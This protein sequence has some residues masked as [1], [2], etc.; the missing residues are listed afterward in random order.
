MAELLDVTS[1]VEHGIVG[2]KMK[3]NKLGH[4]GDLILLR[5]LFKRKEGSGRDIHSDGSRR[6]DVLGRD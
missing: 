6:L 5:Q 3:V 2:V 1:A 4:A